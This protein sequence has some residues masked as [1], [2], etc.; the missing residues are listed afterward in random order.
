MYIDDD[1]ATTNTAIYNNYVP[2]NYF[3]LNHRAYLYIPTTGTYTFNF[4]YRDDVVGVWLNDRAYN[5]YTRRN[6]LVTETYPGNSN[7]SSFT[8]SLVGDQYLPIRVLFG[9]AEY[10]YSFSL[11]VVDPDGNYVIGGESPSGNVVQYSCNP[12]DNAPAFPP[13]GEEES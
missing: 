12:D 1:C 5:G 6:A 3:V 4:E 2:C 8:I 10:G 7:P 9:Q 13:Y 11:S